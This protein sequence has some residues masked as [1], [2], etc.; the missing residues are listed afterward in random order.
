MLQRKKQDKAPGEEL[1]K[2]EIS[3]LP[4]KEIKVTITKMLKELGRRVGEH[5]EK[6]NREFKNIKKNQTEPKI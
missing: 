6:F 2:V 3:N 5:N 4:D 1:S